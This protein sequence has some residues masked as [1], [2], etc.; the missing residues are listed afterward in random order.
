L[1]HSFNTR[2]AKMSVQGLPTY[3]YFNVTV[4]AEY[5]AY[6]EIDRPKKL[7]AFCN[8]M[9]YEMKDIFTRLSSHPDIRA[10]L[11]CSSGDVSNPVS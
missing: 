11:L 2:I 4:P 1:N 3:E 8:A 10:I 5:V 6:V 7:N 9:W